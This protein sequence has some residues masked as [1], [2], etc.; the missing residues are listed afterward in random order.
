[1]KIAFLLGLSTT[2]ICSLIPYELGNLFYSRNDLGNYIFTA[3][4]SAPIFFTSSTMFG[5]LNGLNK[6]GII[7]RNSLII[8]FIDLICLFIFT[9]IPSIN[10]YGYSL[11]LFITSSVS[12]LINFYE[13]KKEINVD[14]SLINI[15]IFA[16]LA[17]LTFMILNI[18]I[19]KF[20]FPLNTV[21][22]L[23]VVA[24]TF[25]IFTYYSSFGET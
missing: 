7:L 2:I 17:L 4:L 10:I 14:I 13:V 11:S 3:S 22:I 6:Q 19:K 9:S 21:E 15:I 12:L 23:L 1:M 5:I 8:A 16:L 20:L 18:I 25:L 24:T